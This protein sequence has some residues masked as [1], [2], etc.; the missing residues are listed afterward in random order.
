LKYFTLSSSVSFSFF[1][2]SSPPPSGT[3]PKAAPATSWPPAPLASSCFSY[4]Y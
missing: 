3:L 2:T 1:A 4:C